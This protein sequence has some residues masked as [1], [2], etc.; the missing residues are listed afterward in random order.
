MPLVTPCYA[1]IH[2][3]AEVILVFVAGSNPCHFYRK[4]SFA[5]RTVFAFIPATRCHESTLFFSLSSLFSIMVTE[6]VFL[7]SELLNLDSSTMSSVGPFRYFF[8][9]K[10]PSNIFLR[11]M[12]Q[13]TSC[14]YMSLIMDTKQIF[15]FYARPGITTS[16]TNA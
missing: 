1:N 5:I 9:V 11:F 8:N 6:P 15:N 7:C 3:P 4:S 2:P 16:V 14:V 10:I 12:Y 13:T